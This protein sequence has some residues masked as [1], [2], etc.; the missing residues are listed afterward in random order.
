MPVDRVTGGPVE[1][2]AGLAAVKA[3]GEGWASLGAAGS[4]A[5]RRADAGAVHVV[6]GGPGRAV[7]GTAAVQP[8]EASRAGT[9]TE[10]SPPACWA[11]AGPADVVTGCPMLTLALV[12]TAWSK[13]SLGTPLLT[14]WAHVASLTQ[15]QAT[16]GIT[17]PVACDAVAGVATVWP[18]V[19]TVTG[20]LAIQA[21]PPRST[22][23]ASSGRVAVPIIATRAPHLT[24]G[25]KPAYWASVLTAAAD[26][27]GEAQAGSGLGVT[28]GIVLT[29]RADLLTAEPP[30]ALRTI[31]PTV[32]PGPA[33][34]AQALPC[35]P[36][37]G[38]TPTGAGA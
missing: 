9:L 38:G 14:P 4:L 26:E 31:C 13:V 12:P 35:D 18:P 23:A 6:A 27:A 2:G 24:A 20:S 37:A 11:G 34:G 15:A 32:L 36:V 17:A 16:D 28:A 19:S 29:H 21:S 5:A 1:A 10:A 3:V 33:W 7:A 22:A 25:S 30:V 8:E